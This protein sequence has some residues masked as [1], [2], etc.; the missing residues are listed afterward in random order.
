MYHYSYSFSIILLLYLFLN[1]IYTHKLQKSVWYLFERAFIC[2]YAVISLCPPSNLIDIVL[3]LLQQI[4]GRISQNSKQNC[5]MPLDPE[6]H[7]CIFD[8][9]YL[10]H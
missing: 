10:M 8:T 7:P 9:L 6:G 4:M 2:Q 1:I 3:L 5:K